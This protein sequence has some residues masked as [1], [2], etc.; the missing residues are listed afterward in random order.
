MKQI[1]SDREVAIAMIICAVAVAALL[2]KEAGL[3]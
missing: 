3:I 1:V 2:L